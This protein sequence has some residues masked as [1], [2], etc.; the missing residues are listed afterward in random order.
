MDVTIERHGE[1]ALMSQAAVCNGTVYL[2]GQVSFDWAHGSVTDQA[3]DILGKIDALLG[4]AGSDRGRMLS[5]TIWLSRAE[6]FAEFNAVWEEWLEGAPP[7]ARATVCGAV[8]ALPGLDI[9][10]LVVA[11]QRSS[12]L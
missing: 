3:R 7:P 6:D 10:I 12:V 1:S 2:S 11:A 5:A 9:E 4:S 8:L